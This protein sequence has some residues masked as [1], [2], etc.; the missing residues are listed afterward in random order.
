MVD[1]DT[2]QQT[3]KVLYKIFFSSSRDVIQGNDIHDTI[4]IALVI[5]SPF[6]KIHI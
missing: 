6:Q 5:L 3:Q 4:L 2:S 1:Q